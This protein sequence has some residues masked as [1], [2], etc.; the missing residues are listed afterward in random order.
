MATMLAAGIAL[1][2]ATAGAA[3]LVDDDAA[4]EF[5]AGA[6]LDGTWVTE[7]GAVSL[8]PAVVSEGFDGPGL[9]SL[10]STP[11]TPDGVA[12]VGSG[13]VTLDGTLVH[14]VPAFEGPQSL[15]FRATFADAPLQHVGL[16]DTLDGPAWAIFSTGGGSVAT[17]FYARTWEDGGTAVD[18]PLSIDPLVAHVY[19]IEW[20]S[21]DVKYFVDGALVATHAVAIAGPMRPVASDFHHGLGAVT[22]DWLGMGGYP[23]SGVFESRVHDA[24]DTR[25]VW[26]RLTTEA[27]GDGTIEVETRAGDT[28]TPDATWSEWQPVG[29]AGEIASPIGRYVQYR[30]SLSHPSGGS[31]SLERVEIEYEIDTVPPTAE[32]DEVDVS[33]AAATVRFSSQDADL[34]RFECRLGTAPFATCASPEVFSGLVTG[35][36]TVFVRAVDAAGN[37]GAAVEQTFSVDTTAPS[38]VIDGVDVSGTTATVRFSSSASDVARFECRLGAAA[39]ATCASPRVFTGLTSGASYAVSVRAVDTT[40]NTGA[41]VSRMFTVPKPPGATTP[42][43]GATTPPPGPTPPP[44]PGPELDDTPPEVQ[45]LTRSARAN[46][47]GVVALRVACPDDEVRC[48]VAVRLKDGRKLAGRKS[49]GVAG[50]KRGQLK[51]RLK[52]ATRTRLATLGRL[53]LTV[54]LT[55]RDETGNRET[56]KLK[57]TVRAPA[58]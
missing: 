54:V 5:A 49:A 52:K 17:G 6:P 44:P 36:Y 18:E 9:G 27:S 1:A 21:T 10:T 56:R 29:S 40:G 25:A 41:A 20:S 2:P 8:R 26:G 51:V 39:F 53:R 33:G 57:L 37:E 4:A 35:S 12:T 43:P 38:T 16:G 28:A 46:R 11:W 30:A 55:A 45:V 32:I 42:P 19:R 23:S 3:P 48:R 34:A 31:P 58:L 50:G 22:L 24:G 13:A 14:T 15:E 47:K 7:P